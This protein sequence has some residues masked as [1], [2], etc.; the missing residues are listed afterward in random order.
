MSCRRRPRAIPPPLHTITPHSS[1]RLAIRRCN[2]LHQNIG[3]AGAGLQKVVGHARGKVG[4]L[5]EMLWPRLEDREVDDGLDV[6][7]EDGCVL[8]AKREKKG[9]SGRYGE[10]GQ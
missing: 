9:R 10:E 4:H 6:D 7:G 2:P 1:R 3:M 5:A 8:D